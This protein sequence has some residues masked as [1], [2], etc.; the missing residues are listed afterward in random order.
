[1]KNI[2]SLKV[3]F[4]IILLSFSINAQEIDFAPLQLGNSWVYQHTSGLLIRGEVNDTSLYIDSIKYFGLSEGYAGNDRALR[5]TEENFFVMKEDSSFPEPFSER[6]YYKK[7]GIIGDTWQVNFGNGGGGVA[8]YTIIDSGLAYRFDTVVTAK[9]VR[10]DFGISDPWDHT[11]TEGFGLLSIANWWTG[12]FIYL[13]GC[14]INGKVYGDT[15]Y[16]TGVHDFTSEITYKL[17]QNYPNPFNSSTIISFSIPQGDNVL[18]E[19]SNILGEKV[20]TLANDYFMAGT[21]SVRFESEN[22]ATGVYFYILRTN[23]LVQTKKM[24]LVR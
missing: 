24:L 11:W 2:F 6:K 4:A 20:G 23:E 1:M 13:K 17:Y 7:N 9:I 16:I 3:L 5:L 10:Q 12:T 8:T 15:T 22:L 18:I 14:V 21:H 19:V